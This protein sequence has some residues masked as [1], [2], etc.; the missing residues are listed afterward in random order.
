MGKHKN[1]KVPLHLVYKAIDSANEVFNQYL[2]TE[3]MEVIMLPNMSTGVA[4][5]EDGNE[6]LMNQIE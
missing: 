5:Y 2:D 6:E 1:K 3:E 4:D